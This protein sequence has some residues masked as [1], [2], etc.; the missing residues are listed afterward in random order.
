[1][2]GTI[3]IIDDEPDIVALTQ[4]FLELGEF[5]TLSCNNGK[6][7]LKLLEEHFQTISL[8]LLDMM[9]PGISGAEVLSK[10]KSR[11]EYEHIK[12]VLF[13]VKS[14]QEDIEHGKSLGADGYITKPFSGLELIEY[15]KNILNK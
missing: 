13:T 11:E 9:M 6:E 15:V 1:M 3:L 7:A 8:V 14:F 5:N 10:I 12:V 4:K 2:L